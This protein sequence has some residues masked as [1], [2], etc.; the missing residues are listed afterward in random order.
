[1]STVY[2]NGKFSA[3]PTSGVQR[4]A[5][6]LVRALDRRLLGQPGGRR[7]V[8]LLPPGAQPPDL[9]AIECRPLAGSRRLHLWEQWS[10]PRAASGGLLLNLSGSAPL[11]ARR[12]V[13]LIH[14][15]A[16]FDV[17]QAYTRAFV[18]WYRFLF[19][20]LARG[21]A[22]LA[23]VSG[24]SRARLALA[25]G[26]PEARLHLVPNGAD[27][28]SAVVP[29]PDILRTLGLA[30]RPFLLAVGSANPTK[31]LESL[32]QAFEASGLARQA[33]LVI[34][35]GRNA[36]VF[37]GGE[38][39][40]SAGVLRL[41]HIGDAPLKALY[42]AAAGLVFP[43][44]Y[45]GFGL[46]P[47]EAMACGC[48]VAASDRA[49]VPEVCGDAARL[50]DPGSRAELTE[51]M[52]S[53]LEDEGLR[54]TLRARGLARAAGFGWDASAAA[55]QQVLDAAMKTFGLALP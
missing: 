1:M 11:R 16:V 50:F 53:L 3:Q 55:L 29:D 46:P 39:P 43:S 10:L 24:F 9:R 45:E 4:V 7:H 49:S 31:N 26:L 51:A 14:D 52:R 35:G 21:P 8:L 28:L 27:H 2:I 25:L 17:P 22:V 42:Q 30:D 36:R 48:P 33:R 41:G 38:A 54:A 23:T 20:R 47:L 5:G 44:S 15:A 32:A 12:Q 40:A 37:A 18:A 13:V 34:A 19:R 6:Q